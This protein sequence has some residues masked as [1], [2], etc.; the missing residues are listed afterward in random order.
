MPEKQETTW[1]KPRGKKVQ[2]DCGPT[3]GAQSAA[4]SIVTAPNAWCWLPVSNS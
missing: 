4:F 3:G 1:S 2:E